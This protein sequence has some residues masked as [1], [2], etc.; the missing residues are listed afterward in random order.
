M[1]GY[2]CP[3]CGGEL[4]ELNHP[5]LVA[6]MTH[7]NGCSRDSDQ[8]PEYV[9]ALGFLF[10]TREVVPDGGDQFLLSEAPI[11]DDFVDDASFLVY[12]GGDNVG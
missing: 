5:L 8:D 10:E 3:D 2:I 4:E 6:A 12:E 11:G 7:S 9:A 1:K